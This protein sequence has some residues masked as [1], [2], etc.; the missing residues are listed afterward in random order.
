MKPKRVRFPSVVKD[1]QDDD[2]SKD[3]RSHH[4]REDSSHQLTE[5]EVANKRDSGSYKDKRDS[6]E[7]L[8]DKDSDKQGS[9]WIRVETPKTVQTRIFC[10]S[11]LL[12]RILLIVLHK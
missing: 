9:V 6:Q 2:Q 5:T 7:N 12:H 3:L 4:K 1:S 8:K 10:F 11:F